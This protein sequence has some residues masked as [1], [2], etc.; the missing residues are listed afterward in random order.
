MEKIQDD[1][2]IGG[3]PMKKSMRQS[4]RLCCKAACMYSI[5]LLS[6]FTVTAG[7][8]ILLAKCSNEK[9]INKKE[10]NVYHTTT[11]AT[12]TTAQTSTTTATT[13]IQTSTTTATTAATTTA[14]TTATTATTMVVTMVQ[15][16]APMLSTIP[17]VEEPQP[18][19][20]EIEEPTDQIYEETSDRVY[21]GNM[22]IT[23]YVATG[24]AT[25]SGEMPYVGGVALSTSYGIPYGTR[26]Y[27]DGFGEYV[28]ND[29]GCAYGVVDVFC[30]TI[31]ECYALTS[32]ADVYLLGG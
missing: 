30:N 25:A 15:T 28:V 31:D 18:V 9:P 13:A 4:I 19:Y 12:S 6:L 26:I 20:E 14:A 24:N 3:Q 22:R 10:V 32:Y 11:A 8:G 2:H 23:G 17:A 29:T 21:L 1:K 7:T 5:L 16:T 27:I